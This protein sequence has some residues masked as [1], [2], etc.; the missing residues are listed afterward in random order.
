[1]RRDRHVGRVVLGSWTIRR[2]QS[3]G[4]AA[5][6]VPVEVVGDRVFRAVG[7]GPWRA[8]GL[9]EDG[10][11][12]AGVGARTVPSATAQTRS[13]RGTTSGG[14]PFPC[15]STPVPVDTSLRFVTIRAGGGVTCGLTAEGEAYSWGGNRY[16]TGGVGTTETLFVPTPVSG[17]LR[18]SELTNHCPHVC[19]RTTD[20]DVNCWG[21]NSGGRLG[22][23][24]TADRSLPVRVLFPA[25]T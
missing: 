20:A 9:D 18:F 15:S 21:L 19:G 14:T 22:D 6:P 10:G 4:F 11:P 17:G 1:M 2:P 12:G 8:C 13:R 7:V 16:G 3:G 23:G 5:S 25:V 24:T